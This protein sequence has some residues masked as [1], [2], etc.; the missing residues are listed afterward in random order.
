M[1]AVRYRPFEN[2]LAGYYEFGNYYFVLLDSQILHPQYTAVHERIHINLGTASSF[3]LFHQFL[4]FLATG[5]SY[6]HKPHFIDQMFHLAVEAGR[7]VHEAAAT[8]HEI[9]TAREHNYEGLHEMLSQLPPEYV[10]WKE[11][12]EGFFDQ[13]ISPFD[14]AGLSYHLARLAMDNNILVDFGEPSIDTIQ[15]FA[16]YISLRENHPKHRLDRFLQVISS[17]NQLTVFSDYLSLS[18]SFSEQIKGAY[19]NRTP[20]NRKITYEAQRRLKQAFECD[21]HRLEKFHSAFVK[22]FSDSDD[23]NNKANE[24][25]RH[26]ANFLIDQGYLKECNFSFINIDTD[27]ASDVIDTREVVMPSTIPQ[28]GLAPIDNLNM[29]PQSGLYIARLFRHASDKPFLLCDNPKRFLVKGDLYV[30]FVP[31]ENSGCNFFM[32]S[33]QET[34]ILKGLLARYNFGL[35]FDGHD[36][37]Q[38]VSLVT[39]D[40]KA[41]IFFIWRSFD[42]FQSTIPSINHCELAI[43]PLAANSSALLIIS[44]SRNLYHLIF[45]VGS[46]ISLV[47]EEIKR[48]S[49][50]ISRL[51]IDERGLLPQQIGLMLAYSNYIF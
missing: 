50:T 13:A 3:G 49:N 18:L 2:V 24:L 29:L 6:I 34:N 48:H 19:A 9:A 16:D 40:S 23:L 12:F 41:T 33:N 22:P 26:W 51:P 17:H 44:T 39:S 25:A 4:H 36:Y 43:T 35:L 10:H 1:S 7:D 27:A 31:L 28:P 21:M 15:G 14:Q 42:Q 32:I 11:V 5:A 20:E 45:A 47:V 37:S 38:L 8:F 46:S 30:R